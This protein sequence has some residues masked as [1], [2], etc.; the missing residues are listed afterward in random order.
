MQ[1]GEENVSL[2]HRV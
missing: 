2:R 1:P